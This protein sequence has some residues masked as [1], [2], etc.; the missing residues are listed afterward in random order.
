MIVWLSSFPRS[1]NTLLRLMLKRVWDIES[2]SMYDDRDDIG[3]NPAVAQRVGHRFLGANFD[4]AYRSMRDSTELFCVKTHDVP[5]DESKS[6]YIVRDGRSAS[7]SYWHYQREY[8]QLQGDAALAETLIGF[9]PFGSWSDH[10]DAWDPLQRP[11]ILMLRYEQL[12]AEPGEQIIRIADFLERRPLRPWEN[13]F[14][15]LHQLEPRFFREGSKVPPA[16]FDE[17]E[18][19]LFW[20]MHGAWMSRL[21]YAS[22]DAVPATASQNARQL[23]YQSIARHQGRLTLLNRAFSQQSVERESL[24]RQLHDLRHQLAE[25]ANQMDAKRR[26]SCAEQ[27][28]ENWSQFSLLRAWNALRASSLMRSL[29]FSRPIRASIAATLTL[30]AAAIHSE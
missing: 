3:A 20:L 28:V 8:G 18:E 29:V 23:V 10:L 13:D 12:L 1:G 14:G 7:Y 30:L 4:D 25:A 6:I 24:E 15:A 2:C 9:T 16:G 19:S 21:G 17:A 27:E 11:E 5:I 26:L 22:A